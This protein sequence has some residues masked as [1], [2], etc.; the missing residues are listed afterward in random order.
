MVWSHAVVILGGALVIGCA[1]DDGGAAGTGD[2]EGTASA[3]TST[4]CDRP[5]DAKVGI[6]TSCFSPTH[7]L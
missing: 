2:S 1:S 3:T 4:S 7:E 5:G 6:C